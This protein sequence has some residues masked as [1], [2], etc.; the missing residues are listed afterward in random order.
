[1]NHTSPYPNRSYYN[2]TRHALYRLMCEHSEQEVVELLIN[3]QSYLCSEYRPMNAKLSEVLN[4]LDDDS[5]AYIIE[6]LDDMWIAALHEIY[7]QV[8]DY[9]P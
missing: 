5:R 7:P 8:K 9:K 1:M 2:V 4:R 6:C 3:D